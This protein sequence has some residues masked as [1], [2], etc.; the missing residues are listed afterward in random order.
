MSAYG[1]WN[2]IN[3][4][5]VDDYYEMLDCVSGSF[6]DPPPIDY[7]TIVIDEDNV[8]ASE[9]DGICWMNGRPVTEDDI[10]VTAYMVMDGHH[11]CLAA[12][13]RGFT[14]IIGECFDKEP[15]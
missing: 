12:I 8:E 15:V 4:D 13:R 6:Q 7:Y 5:D 9:L 14:R 3:D 2:E 1:G 10:G 11:R